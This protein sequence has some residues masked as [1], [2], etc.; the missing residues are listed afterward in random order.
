M[1][2]VATTTTG[3]PARAFRIVTGMSGAGKSMVHR[4]FED[5]GHFCVDNLPIGMIPKLAEMAERGGPHLGRVALTVDVREREFLPE[6][7]AV[8]HE[9]RARLR[10]V[11]LIFVDAD[12]ATLVQRFSET[13]RPHPL[14]GENRTLVDAIAAER[15]L[16]QNLRAEADLILDTTGLTVHELRR[17]VWTRFADVGAQD[18]MQVSIVSFAYRHGVPKQADL[19]FDVRFLP[20]P[21]F[22]AALRPYSGQDAPVRDFLHAREEYREFMDRLQDLLDFLLPGYA[23]EGKS[24][25][26][27]AIGCTGGR[28]RSVAITEDLHAT[29]VAKGV[30]ALKS[31]RDCDRHDT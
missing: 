27:I 28:H 23:R 15:A 7:P 4:C 3:H 18:R 17:Y 22:D 30:R 31:H 6:L 29:L 1:T 8:L 5:M 12:D 14:S 21:Y 11:E 13:R 16:L 9:L 20:N 2:D 26:T 25:L 24:Y 10:D 19:V